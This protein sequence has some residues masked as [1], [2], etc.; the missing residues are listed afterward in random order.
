MADAVNRKAEAEL[1]GAVEVAST[2]PSRY[3][4]DPKYLAE[5]MEK[6]F[7]R[8]WQIV[9]RSEQVARPGDYFTAQLCGEPLL[10]V[11]D[12]EMKLRGFYNVCRHRAG[13]P[14]EGCGS[15]KVFRC[16]YHGWTYG[17]DGRLLNAPEME[18]TSNFCMEE[19]AL[20][21][22][23]V[24]E[25]EGQV[26]V[27]LNE[28][29]EELRE[30]LRELPGQVAKYKFGEM[31]LAGRRDYHMQCNWKVYI[32][33]YL[34]GYHL[35]SVHPSLNR[36]LDYNAYVT[37]LYERHSAQV[38]P[39]RGPENEANVERRYKQADGD[40]SAE[41][42]WIFPNWMLNCYPD[43][44]SLNIVLPTGSE[45]CVAIFEWYFPEKTIAAAEETMK[46]SDEIQLEDGK[47][48]ETVHKNLKSRSYD[49]GRYSVKQERGVHQFHRLYAETMK[50]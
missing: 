5:E 37:T 2:L 28:H 38:S 18:G 45:T 48:C 21:P 39:I 31:K 9:G 22:V 3:Y 17:L 41:Y 36:E 40:L 44:V 13:P 32:D 12:A 34:E 25:W 30:A 1:I 20:R 26:F 49:R 47:I 23:R 6:I 24:E 50:A 16:G 19:F 42:Y 7:A 46:F 15:R 14:A 4:V 35:P 29:A 8:T 27:N 10:L 33:N 43:N 11:K